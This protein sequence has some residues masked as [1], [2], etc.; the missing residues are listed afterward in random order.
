MEDDSELTQTIYTRSYFVELVNR[1]RTEDDIADLITLFG[2]LGRDELELALPSLSL[3]AEKCPKGMRDRMMD[4][5]R[6]TLTDANSSRSARKAAISCLKTLTRGDPIWGNFFTLAQCLEEPQFHILNPVLPRMDLVMQSVYSNMLDFKWAK[7]LL[8]RALAHSNGWIRLWALEKLVAVKANFLASDQNLLFCVLLKHLDSN[9]PFWRL[10]ERQRLKSFLK[11]LSNLF[12]GIALSLND[13]SREDFMRETL[14]NVG[15]ISNPSSLY[16]MSE[17]LKTITPSRCLCLKDFPLII[18]LAQKTRYIQHTTM[19]LV[20]LYNFVLFFSKTLEQSCETINELGV[21][22]ALFSREDPSLLDG[23]VN[24]NSSKDLLHHMKEPLDMIE[25]AV[26]CR[27]EF[28]RDDFAILLWTR[29]RLSG[30][31]DQLQKLI[32]LELADRL[33]AVEEGVDMVLSSTMVESVNTLLTLLCTSPRDLTSV[34]PGLT[35]LIHGYILLR[36]AVTT[37]T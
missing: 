6:F 5:I 21:L 27:R 36:C 32:E 26:H 3:L 17:T 11:S 8:T 23:F 9:D 1:I 29:A 4:L 33:M 12:E 14:R 35:Q 7:V 19:R 2:T 10:L 34:D 37:A 16:F 25:V 24:E 20:T 22:T 13:G 15:L 31:D 28:H 30:H 18:N